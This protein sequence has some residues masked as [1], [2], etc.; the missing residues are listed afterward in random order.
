MLQ[1]NIKIVFWLIF[2]VTTGIYL[3][4][5]SWSLPMITN[6]AGGLTPFDMRPSGYSFEEA[7]AF[8]TALPA[9]MTTFYRETQIGVLDTYYPALLA[10]TLFL[11][12]GLLAPKKLKFW[13]WVL[14][15]IAIPSA[16]F[17]YMENTNINLMLFL[18]PDNINMEIVARAS[19]RSVAK[20]TFSTLAMSIVLIFGIVKLWNRFRPP[21]QP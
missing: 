18:G 13:G 8:L 15:L 9:D 10:L 5:L 16:V 14:A 7:K 19:A 17:D 20:A 4:M 11:A 6:A 3:T 21:V 12:I 1:R 2:A